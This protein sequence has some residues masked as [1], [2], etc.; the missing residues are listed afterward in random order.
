M[1]LVGLNIALLMK[2]SLQKSVIFLLNPL[3]PNIFVASEGSYV[4]AAFEY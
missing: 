3:N 4:L 2:V 1:R